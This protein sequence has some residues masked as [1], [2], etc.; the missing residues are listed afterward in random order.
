MHTVYFIGG[1]HNC[2]FV[3]LSCFMIWSETEEEADGRMKEGLVSQQCW[4]FSSIHDL[5][6][7]TGQ[8]DNEWPCSTVC[9]LVGLLFVY[10]GG[11]IDCNKEELL[12]Y[13]RTSSYHGYIVLPSSHLKEQ[14]ENI[15]YSQV[16]SSNQDISYMGCIVQ[17]AC[18][19]SASLF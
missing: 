4:Q 19:P 11:V 12:V 8:R 6:P 15:L 2:S 5:T 14:G 1:E 9:V 13:C 16:S 18:N 3:F 17:S 7:Q 10:A